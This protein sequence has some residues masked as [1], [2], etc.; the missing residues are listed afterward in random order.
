MSLRDVYD[1]DDGCF[2]SNPDTK[3]E[4]T[5]YVLRRFGRVTYWR[6]HGAYRAIAVVVMVVV[7]L[8][9]F[10]ATKNWIMC[11]TT[12]TVNVC[13]VVVFFVNRVFTILHLQRMRTTY[14]CTLIIREHACAK[15]ARRVFKE[16]G[17]KWPVPPGAH[18]SYTFYITDIIAYYIY[19]SYK[20]IYFSFY[21]IFRSQHCKP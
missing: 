20:F 21:R 14:Y 2:N 1:H 3:F 11:N 7:T 19:A 10:G 17:P 5:N 13:R 9:K 8:S 16:G 15:M 18:R 12:L 4:E 6:M